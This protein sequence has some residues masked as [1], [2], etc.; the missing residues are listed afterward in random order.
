MIGESLSEENSILVRAIKL[1][2]SLETSGL[3]LTQTLQKKVCSELQ[4]YCTDEEDPESE[5]GGDDEDGSQE[6]EEEE[7]TPDEDD[8]DD[9]EDKTEM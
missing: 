8:A 9:G 4:G 6:N 5:E 3:K 2:K 1:R 7:E